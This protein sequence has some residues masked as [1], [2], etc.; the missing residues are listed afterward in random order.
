VAKALIDS[1]VG[2]EKFANSS[3]TSSKYIYLT[4]GDKVRLADHNLP[5]SYD[6]ADHEYR[7]GGDLKE[8]IGRILGTNPE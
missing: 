1:G 6:G 5:I 3:Q 7:Y 2:V 8:F 4:N